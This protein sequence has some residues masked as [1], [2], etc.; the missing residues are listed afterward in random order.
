[1][2][3]TPMVTANICK[4]LIYGNVHEII[5]S[6]KDNIVSVKKSALGVIGND[7]EYF[8]MNLKNIATPSPAKSPIINLSK[9]FKNILSALLNY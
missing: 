1:M 9:T 8:L 7:I 6:L 4:I 5:F 2:N 3:F